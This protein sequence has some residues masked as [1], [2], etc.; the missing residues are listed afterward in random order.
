MKNWL[1]ENWFKIAILILL[2][3]TILIKDGVL[4]LIF[5]IE[6]STIIYNL[7]LG[8]GSLIAGFAGLRYIDDWLEKQK[9][10]RLIREYNRKY[11]KNL[12]N[13]ELGWEL[14]HKPNR[15]GHLHLLDRRDKTR[16]WIANWETFQDLFVDVP[17]YGIQRKDDLFNQYEPKDHIIT[18][19]QPKP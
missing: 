7:G 15:K 5:S 6:G 4:K 1:K 9:R 14:T 12:E 19:G 10:K 17:E 13:Q 8:I 11:P 2:S 18:V 16:H 3:I